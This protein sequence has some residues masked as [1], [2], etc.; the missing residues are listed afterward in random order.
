MN[1]DLQNFIPFQVSGNKIMVNASDLHKYLYINTELGVWFLKMLD[2]GFQ[3][4]QDYEKVG[5]DYKITVEMAK[6]IA[7]IQKSD[8]GLNVRSFL[9]SLEK[10][11]NKVQ[12][13]LENIFNMSQGVYRV[14]EVEGNLG[15]L[16][17][18]EP[19]SVVSGSED[20]TSISG[21]LRKAP[22]ISSR[23]YGNSTETSTDISVNSYKSTSGKVKESQTNFRDSAKL[24]GVRENLLVN[25][26]L[27]NNYCYRDKSGNIK[28]YAKFMD[29]FTMRLFT[30][31]S[32]HSGVQTMINNYGLESFK[33][34]LKDENVIK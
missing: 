32:G 33:N 15:S 9:N 29:F 11:F 26:L 4:G 21:K 13:G 12:V 3:E 1:R 17:V 14:G 34:M 24:I 7:L 28:P 27:L 16:E 30:T 6:E 20:L 23:D 22:S 5:D 19:S 10:Q 8:K 25:W 31:T 2:Y 18:R